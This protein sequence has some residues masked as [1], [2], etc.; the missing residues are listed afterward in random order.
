[1]HKWE[2]YNGLIVYD[3]RRSAFR[4]L[5]NAGVP[6]KVAK[7]VSGHKTRSVFDRYHMV[8]ADDITNAMRRLEVV[9]LGIQPVGVKSVKTIPR[10]SSKLLKGL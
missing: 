7:M 10:R 1:V 5:V 9:A 8:S 4:N 2:R 6:E 3:L